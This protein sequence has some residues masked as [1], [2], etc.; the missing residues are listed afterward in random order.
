MGPNQ[1]KN[2][3]HCEGNCQQNENA[4][5]LMGEDVWKR[6]IWLGLNIQSIQRIHKTQHKKKKKLVKIRET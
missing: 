4:T 2:L 1:T 3:S 6:H 5:Y